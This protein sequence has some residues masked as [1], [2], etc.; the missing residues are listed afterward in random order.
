MRDNQS[1]NRSLLTL[2]DGVTGL[3][4]YTHCLN[5]MLESSYHI[6]F[7]R[8]YHQ[9]LDRSMDNTYCPLARDLTGDTIA[10]PP[11]GFECSQAGGTDNVLCHVI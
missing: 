4:E 6:H 1:I 9:Q 5:Y 2:L 11:I 3:S 10:R 8:E 7:R